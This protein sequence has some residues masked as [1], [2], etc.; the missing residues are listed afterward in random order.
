VSCHVAARPGDE[1]NGWRLGIVEYRFF[2]RHFPG[3][4]S[5]RV[6]E[7]IEGPELHRTAPIQQ[8]D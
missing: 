1:R 8:A 3:L 5:P 7:P 4:T 2:N 6:E